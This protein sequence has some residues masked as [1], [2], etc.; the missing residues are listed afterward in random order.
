MLGLLTG[1]LCNWG[2]FFLNIANTLDYNGDVTMFSRIRFKKARILFQ[3]ILTLFS[4]FG[5]NEAVLA[6]RY[7]NAVYISNFD[8]HMSMAAST[9]NQASW[10]GYA[11]SGAEASL[12]GDPGNLKYNE[13]PLKL[14]DHALQNLVDNSAIDDP[15]KSVDLVI[16]IAG[17]D[18]YRKKDAPKLSSLA[19]YRY[20]MYQHCQNTA[21]KEEHFK[22]M[23][24]AIFSEKGFRVESVRLVGDHTLMAAGAAYWLERNKQKG[25]NFDLIHATTIAV[26]YQIRDEKITPMSAKLPEWLRMSGGYWEVGKNVSQS[27]LSSLPT[28]DKHWAD[29]ISSDAVRQTLNASDYVQDY[30]RVQSKEHAM[31]K[32]WEHT[33]VNTLGYQAG[34]ILD[35]EQKQDYLTG[36]HAVRLETYDKAQQQL[37]PVMNK[38]IESIAAIIN[39]KQIE[40]YFGLA[41]DERYPIVIMGEFSSNALKTQASQATLL[42][43]LPESSRDRVRFV[44]GDSFFDNLA[45]GSRKLLPADGQ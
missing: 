26:P 2:T 15:D 44:P 32:R 38:T 10:V 7:R 23:A 4:F 33:G 35:T 19:D 3:V 8:A 29:Y 21:N 36:D 18:F 37:T 45:G 28:T 16:G 6:A 40:Y 43:S 31:L 41:V 22:C 24:K 17:Y 14:L 20:T 42:K 11:G 12:A 1:L 34:R 30:D 39:T 13:S 5:F 27:W 25:S 9:V